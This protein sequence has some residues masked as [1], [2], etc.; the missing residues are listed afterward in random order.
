MSKPLRADLVFS[1]WI[2]VWFLLYFFQLIKYSPKFAL[3]L[4]LLDNIVMLILMI[5]F[6]TSRITIFMFII[7]NTIIKVFPLYYLR[8]ERIRMNDVYFT[9]FLF[10]LFVIWIHMNRQTLVGNL[11]IIHD[12]LLYG[13]NKTPIMNI[14]S[15]IK[16]IKLF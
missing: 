2:Y 9:G 15:N 4:G 7:V 14:L 5:L 13:Q 6:G 11:K 3:M 10:F 12:S 8:K 1:Y 16:K